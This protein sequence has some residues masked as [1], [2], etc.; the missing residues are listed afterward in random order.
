VRAGAGWSR[1]VAGD[2]TL[3]A[4]GTTVDGGLGVSYLWRDRAQGGLRRLGLRV[5]SRLD[6]RA[7]GL[8]HG[9]DK[10]RVGPTVTGAL[11]MGF[12]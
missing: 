4:D 6:V 12:R 9:E 11:V 5:E 10:L 1:D 3:S 8:A 2:G 7:G